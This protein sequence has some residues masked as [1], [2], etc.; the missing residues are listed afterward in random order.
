MLDFDHDS[1][2]YVRLVSTSL[3]RCN[4]TPWWIMRLSEIAAYASELNDA[5]CKRR[6]FRLSS[7][8]MSKDN[9][10]NQNI[11]PKLDK[12]GMV[13][14]NFLVMRRPRRSW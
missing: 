14:A 9:C 1:R 10:W 7:F 12:I 2:F 13:W 4:V 6:C 3:F 8:V 5:V 11:K